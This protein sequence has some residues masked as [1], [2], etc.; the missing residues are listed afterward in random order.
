[1]ATT[2]STTIKLLT[3][4]TLLCLIFSS[5]SVHALQVDAPCQKLETVFARGSGQKTNQAENNNFRDKIKDRVEDV[6]EVIHHYELGTEKYGGYQY[7]AVSVENAWNAL[8]ALGSSG[9]GN[10]YGASVNQGVIEFRSYLKERMRVC[11]E[12]YF[13]LGG[14]SQGAQVIGQLLP[15]LSQEM[16]NRIIYVALFGDP[17][18]YFPEGKQSN[19]FT[20]PP[21]CQGK[22]LSPYRVVIGDCFLSEGRLGARKP[23]LPNDMLYK[24][25]LWCYADDYVC[26]TSHYPFA[27]GHTTYAG[28]GKAINTAARKAAFRLKQAIENEPPQPP[29][30]QGSAPVHTP[31]ISPALI[32]TRYH[33][34]MGLNGQDVVYLV[35]VSGQMSSQLPQIR[36]N[37]KATVPKIIAKGG[38]VALF[39]YNGYSQ[40]A[41]GPVFGELSGNKTTDDQ[42]IDMYLQ[43][44]TGLPQGT[45][46]GP[47]SSAMLGLQWNFGASKSLIL[48]TNRT[49][50]GSPDI[51]GFTLQ[52]IART[53]LAIDPVNIYPV[54]PEEA[55]GEYT[56]LAELTSG[57]VTTYTDDIETAMDQAF[58]KTQNRPVPFLKNT[59]YLADPGQEIRFDASDSYVIDAEI[60][61]YDWDFEGDGVFDATT[62]GPVV[63]HTYTDI[64]DGLMQVRVTASNGL[65]AN[66][67][68]IVKIGTYVVPVV[69][70]APESLQVRVLE[71]VDDISKVE[72]T[73]SAVTDEKTAFIALSVNGIVIGAMTRD[74]TSIIVTDIDRSYDNDFGITALDA[75]GRLGHSIYA[76][77][78]MIEPPVIEQPAVSTPLAP[79]QQADQ[80][81]DDAPVLT[82]TE[83][84]DI[85]QDIDPTDDKVLGTT[86]SAK[87]ETSNS[88]IA[89]YWL[90]VPFLI[91][92]GL[93]RKFRTGS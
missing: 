12:S 27:E 93:F 37:L 73:W 47:L 15:A 55:S 19:W 69:A 92:G 3:L 5:N 29:P 34:G 30:S 2:I 39:I 8:G 63:H 74:R 51:Y 71:T 60:A 85:R 10:V 1:M 88:G 82:A 89:W 4:P 50:L 61:K 90:L 38:R 65:H 40:L 76:S 36:K 57:H 83:D 33:F 22:N 67:S 45:P 68:A 70:R 24:T 56:E 32:D 79:L 72:L 6:Y 81:A 21:A 14:Y 31:P 59:E 66:M 84:Y 87:P 53:S 11:G 18:L 26:G 80:P 23:Y 75:T 17:K 46:L 58:E 44:H 41:A 77:L 49:P 9:M 35:D 25:D 43:V 16:R 42:L 20:P 48:L 28:D 86:T 64:F 91:V 54:V 78:Q 13:I 52:S 7:P 62:T